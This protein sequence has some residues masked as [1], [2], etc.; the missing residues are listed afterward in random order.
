MN[1]LRFTLLLLSSTAF[2]TAASAQPAVTPDLAVMNL[3]ELGVYAVGY[4]YR[5]QPEQQFPLGWSGFFEDRTGVA[6][7]PF[8]AQNGE[9]AFLL[10]CPWRNGTG[11]SFQQ[12]VFSLPAQAT[13]ILLQG[14]TAMR[15]QN[16]TNSDG[17]TFRLYANG[18]K[19]FD[20]H[21]TNDVWRPFQFDFT[22][23][24]GT[25][26]TVRF[27]VD[28]GPNNNASFDYSL[29][30][31]RQLVLEGYTPPILTRPPPPSLALS[32]LW[33]GQTSE[34]APPSGF[35]G[36]SSA[37]LSNSVVHLRYTGS[38]G[39]LDYQWSAPQS[40]NDGLFGT[41][42][43][44]AQMTGDTSIT[45]PL[46]N[47][48]SLSW[49]QTATPAASGWLQTNVG[50]TLWR[51]FNVGS[52]TATVRIT[53][54]LVGKSLALAVTCDKPWVTA[55]DAGAWG[56]VVRR[57]PVVVPYYPGSAYYFTQEGLFVNA[58]LDWTASA[59]TSQTGTKASYSALTDGTLVPLRERALFTAAW[60]LAE[61][62]PNPP[63]PPS[64]W[65]SFLANKVMLDI[66]GGTFAN[67]AGNLT[68]LASYGITNCVAI[69]HDWQRSGYDNA[70]P[71]H[72][73]A[74]ASY[75]GD[76]G[77]S[78]LVAT[79]TSL[80]I[81]CALHENYVD[82]YPNYDFYNTNDI[83]LDSA[84]NL[85]LAWYNPGTHIQSFAEKPNAI[86]RLAA[87]QSPEIHRRYATQANYLDVH[88]AVP[89]W[90]HVDQRAGETGAGQ[91]SRVW[92]IHRQLW[93]YERDT[94]TGPV[95]GEGNNHW[96]WS[97]CLD[98]VEAQFGSGWPGNGGFTAPLAVDFDL[99]KIHPLQFN[100][101]M[102][103]YSRWWPSESYQTNWAGPAPM[104]VL[105]RY[106]MQE[107]AYGH[108]GFLDSS[109]Y[110]N[111]PLAWLEHHLLSPV[112][113]RY[114]SV[115]PLEILYETNGAWL[116]ATAMA[117]TNS[118]DAWNRVRVRYENGLVLIANAGSNAFTTGKWLL[119]DLGWVAEG[120]G[121]TAGTT[122][123]GG[124]ITD[125]ADTGD[126][127]FL[128]ARSAADWNLSS[129]RRV[130]PS[131]AAFQQT[132]TRAFRVTYGWAVQDLLAKNYTCFVHFCTNGVICAQQDH[133]PAPPTS[134]WQPG[135]AI[136]DGPWNVSLPSTLP[137]GD[138]DWLLG[139]YDATGDGSRVPLQG[140]DDGTLRI[141][142]GGL[143]LT[144]AGTLIT[145]TA[146]TNLP[147]FDPTAWYGQHL[148]NSN[149]VVD[150][151]DARTD[152]SVLLRREGNVWLLKTW[153]R[154]RNFTLEF[155]RT[156]FD[157]PA[158][159]QC[160]GGAASTVTPVPSGSRWV[161]PLNGA[162]EYRWTNP[163]PR[164]SIVLTNSAELVS[165]PASADNFMLEATTDL[166][167]PP[168]WN[169]VTSPITNI[170]GQISVILPSLSA[171][172]FHRLKLLQ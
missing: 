60:H 83:A 47:S 12:F 137:D 126:T 111:I 155:S 49:S 125:F 56:P 61:M 27:E 134:Q 3:D 141:R 55:L 136:S 28:P 148:N 168:S 144:N 25:N 152:G 62:L 133:V 146:E 80:G 171:R 46:A 106:R 19:L 165:W 94:H 112:M 15:S 131:V 73:P 145:F 157:Q 34:V 18:N 130:R 1:H 8:G 142:L 154:Q 158:K 30:G 167:P 38:D 16:V 69:I 172:Q 5:G 114:A 7:E 170:N 70:L 82:Y 58:L 44:N 77:M 57:R 74:N 108:A 116:D 156:R 6:C 147:A 2:F 100:H 113:A 51:T 110:A 92:D 123:R 99:L 39:T 119:P 54:Q 87:T 64:P 135:Q 79:G 88:S 17:V 118:P 93:A 68:N 23:L 40:A 53:G 20:Y 104:V 97:G 117:K 76:V 89:P 98:G 9:Q 22:A 132:G 96:Y 160:T 150:F 102:G 91:F 163:P 139:L 101:G 151:G 72:Y 36:A 13:R 124:V 48:A 31:N 41:I 109:V 10:H 78:N 63:N 67:I 128:N 26:L 166:A 107:A 32:N 45:V 122:L 65:R 161:L 52:T 29:W 21:Q 153:P 14:A 90:F 75:G 81:R 24:R 105:D 140:L 11:I 95:F 71:M 4:A 103:Y 127:L 59:A 121:V 84:G 66:W 50:Y 85:Q 42:T 120:A 37:S 169:P 138:Y 115:R 164:L 159:V 162:S 129:Y 33:S 35:P 86:L 149:S 43:L 143:H